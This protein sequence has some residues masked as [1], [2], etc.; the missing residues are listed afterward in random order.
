M[1]NIMLGMIGLFVTLYT[2]LAGL[3]I[4]YLQTQKN[5][6]EKHV[7]RIVKNTLEMQYQT[8]E[9]EIVEAMLLQ[10][11]REAVSSKNAT[12][13]VEVQGID[14]QKGLLSVKVT[15]HVEMLNGREKTIVVEKTAILERAYI[16]NT[17]Y[18]GHGDDTSAGAGTSG[19]V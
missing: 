7:S 10:E 8:G 17:E 14:L 6:L 3:D 1:K 18:V 5:Q 2:L 13:E 4:L 19:C 11:I 16:S 12:L 15:K 9:E